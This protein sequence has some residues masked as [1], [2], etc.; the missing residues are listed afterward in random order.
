MFNMN[1]WLFQCVLEQGNCW[2]ITC[3]SDWRGEEEA[4]TR[5]KYFLR[6]WGRLNWEGWQGNHQRQGGKA[7]L[8]LTC[9]VSGALFL[10]ERP[11]YFCWFCLM[12]LKRAETS[13]DASDCCSSWLVVWPGGPHNCPLPYWGMG[14]AWG[15]PCSQGV[16]RHRPG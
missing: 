9:E 8:S 1:I 6:L 16:Q 4:R 15:L 2:G 10:L 11:P 12:S 14:L 13:S 5:C 7:E 3:G